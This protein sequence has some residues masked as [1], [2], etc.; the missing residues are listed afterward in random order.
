M[1]RLALLTIAT[2]L[3][4][5][6]PAGAAD[7]P[8]IAREVAFPHAGI[9]VALPEG[10]ELQM[11]AEPFEVARAVFTEGG[12]VREGLT[13]LALPYRREMTA[14]QYAEQM[15]REMDKNLVIRNLKV[16]KRVEMPVAGTKGIVQLQS[17]TYRDEETVAASV[18][19]LRPPANGRIGICYVL[20]VEAGR[21]RQDRLLPLLG[22][23][24]RSVRTVDLADP[25]AIPLGE[26]VGTIEDAR[27]GF[28]LG[29]P[30]GYAAGSAQ[31]SV[32]MLQTDYLAG[33]TP[34]IVVQAPVVRVAADQSAE[35]YA[36]R[37]I[38]D[39]ATAGGEQ[40]VEV[41]VVSKGPAALAGRAGY[42][43]VLRRRAPSRE[44][45][46]PGAGDVVVQR[47]VCASRGDGAVSYSLVAICRTD[48]PEAAEAKLDQIADGYRLLT[49][50]PQPPATAPAATTPATAPA[51]TRPAGD[52]EELLDIEELGEPATAPAGS[53]D[54][55]NELDDLLTPGG[56]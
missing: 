48:D 25:T 17:Y 32:Y 39:V 23:I 5:W 15:T 36:K 47:S 12:K 29:V 20:T 21:A 54:E 53:D 41:E 19:F 55:L 9:A 56:I 37:C 34:G 52:A 50:A 31:G 24:I 7:P 49:E 45:G 35:A 28:S 40:G 22:P 18:Y 1:R 26:T 3:S 46:G 44:G 13:V 16:R 2:C 51:T 27:L 33:A 14:R 11:V 10:F 6:T 30:A 8:K 38:Q 43:F 4:A 42:Q